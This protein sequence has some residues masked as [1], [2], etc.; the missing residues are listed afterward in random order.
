MYSANC[1]IA[2]RYNIGERKWAC[3]EHLSLLADEDMREEWPSPTQGGAGVMTPA[4]GDR[5]LGRGELGMLAGTH[6]ETDKSSRLGNDHTHRTRFHLRWE[7]WKMPT[8]P[9]SKL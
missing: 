1:P 2:N 3:K 4:G 8:I 7:L 5:F 6:E 9:A